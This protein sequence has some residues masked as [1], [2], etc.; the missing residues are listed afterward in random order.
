MNMNWSENWTN[1]YHNVL[2]V[3]ICS[4]DFVHIC[5]Y[6]EEALGYLQDDKIWNYDGKY[7]C[8][9]HNNWVIDK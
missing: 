2:Y 7:L 3:V 1:K 6:E 9:F 5:S 8:R 4:D